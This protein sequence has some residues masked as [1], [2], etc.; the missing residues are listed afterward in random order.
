MS[1]APDSVP[2]MD[3]L[4]IPGLWLDGSAWDAVL[5]GLRAAGHTPH[6]MTLPG[7]G[8]GSASATLDDQLDAVV[9]A[10]DAADGPVTVVGHSAGAALAWLAADREVPESLPLRDVQPR[11]TTERLL[12]TVTESVMKSLFSEWLGVDAPRALWQPRP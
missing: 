12:S 7:Q 3:V 5:P 9:V 6:P 4:L 10:I 8:D 1:A 2:R 11:S